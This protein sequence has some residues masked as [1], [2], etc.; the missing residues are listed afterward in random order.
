[1]YWTTGNV[2]AECA[3]CD[4]AA[5]LFRTRKNDLGRWPMPLPLGKRLESNRGG[6]D[7][8]VVEGAADELNADRQSLRREAARHADGRQ[9]AEVADAA[10]GIGE[11]ELGLDVR[12][13]RRRRD[14]QRGGGADVDLLEENVDL[15]LQDAAQALGASIAGGGDG[16]VHVAA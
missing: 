3:L 7:P 6:D 15:P 16:H 12:F 13:H 1:M 5:D 4:G 11:S 8:R 9:A 2:R 14:R 10:E